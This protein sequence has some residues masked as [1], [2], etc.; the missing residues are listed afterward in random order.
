MNLEDIFKDYNITIQR[1]SRKG[2]LLITG[3]E[4]NPMTIGWGQLGFVWGKP[5]FTVMVRPSRYSYNLI[6][7]ER[8]FS[9]NVMPEGAGKTLGICGSKSGRDINKRS[10]CGL[11]L[12]QGEKISI[13]GLKEA[14]IIYECKIIHENHLNSKS[15]DPELLKKYYSTGDFHSLYFGEVLNVRRTK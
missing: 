14:E 12:T 3:Q 10:E 13:P 9:I 5:I 6:E 15:L 4:G 11:N 2:V 1:M 8:E 7:S